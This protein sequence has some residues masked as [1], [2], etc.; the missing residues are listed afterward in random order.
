MNVVIIIKMYFVQTRNIEK[1]SKFADK[2]Y[3]LT[4]HVSNF[5]DESNTVEPRLNKQTVKVH[6][7]PEYT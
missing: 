3:P 2:M 6:R 1:E 7:L 4:I 5:V